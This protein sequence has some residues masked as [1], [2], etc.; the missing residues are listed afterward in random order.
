MATVDP[1]S[2]IATMPS[3]HVLK[4]SQRE[5][6]SRTYSYRQDDET[7]VIPLTGATAAAEM[8]KKPG[9]SLVESFT[10]VIDEP[11]GDITLSLTSEETAAIPF[12][13]YEYD[14]VVTLDGDTFIMIEGT[15]VV[16]GTV[17]EG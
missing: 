6:F 16:D 15:L 2:T 3:R 10:V 12:G 7:T 11:N 14:I 9:G 4:F 8:R 17:T 5:S 13:R 1:R